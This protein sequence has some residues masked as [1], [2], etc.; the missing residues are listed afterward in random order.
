MNR[1]E[2][3]GLSNQEHRADIESEDPKRGAAVI[4]I[5]GREG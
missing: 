5:L 4:D 1:K 3:G 2:R